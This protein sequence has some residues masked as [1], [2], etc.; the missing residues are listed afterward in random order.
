ML[1][2]PILS[3]PLIALRLTFRGFAICKFKDF[4]AKSF[5]AKEVEYFG[6]EHF[7]NSSIYLFKFDRVNIFKPDIY[8]YDF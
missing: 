7:I 5:F 4:N 2:S 1:L 3:H 8:S 6:N